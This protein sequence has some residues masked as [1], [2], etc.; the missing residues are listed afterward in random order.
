MS[1]SY[2]ATPKSTEEIHRSL[3][4]QL[5]FSWLKRDTTAFNSASAA[6]SDTGVHISGLLE[7]R[8]HLL[9]IT[10]EHAALALA[11]SRK[12]PKIREVISVIDG[13]FEL[14]PLVVKI[15]VDH[16]RRSGTRISYRVL[17][18]G[19][20]QLYTCPDIASLYYAP[21]PSIVGKISTWSHQQNWMSIDYSQDLSKQLRTAAIKGMETHF[22]AN[23]KTSYGAAVVAEGRVYFA[24]VYSS[25]D[26]RM[27][28]HA[29]MVAA[30][31]AIAD[32]HRKISH[33]AVISDKAVDE[34][35]HLCGCCRQF[36]I[37][38]EQKTKIPI[39]V[40][41]FSI[42]GKLSFASSLTEYL[43]H[44]WDSGLPLE[45]RKRNP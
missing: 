21:P 17:D 16:A 3:V 27:N 45:E 12:D 23:T 18:K 33:V 8:T 29:E 32:G 28:L 36:L 25:F 4:E 10:S 15:L 20:K 14:N 24:G 19:G 1:A 35:P 30:L 6:I 44:A 39:N 11:V 40:S 42:D 5:S 34:L 2:A 43:P 37:E 22:S 41:V 31:S 26:K 38:I 13:L 9:D 7:S